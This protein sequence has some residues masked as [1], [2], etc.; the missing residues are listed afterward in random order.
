MTKTLTQVGEFG[1]IERMKR[2]VRVTP[3]VCKGIGDDAA[4]LTVTP[5]M[6]LVLTTD[7]LVE[8]VHFT[9]DMKAESVGQKAMACNVSDI[10]AMGAVPRYAVV[11]LGVPGA[12]PLRYVD[13][14]YRGMNR[15]AEK[16]A[17]AIVGGD[18]VSSEKIVLNIA[19]T[20]EAKDK[21]L[22][23]RHGAKAGDGIFVTGPLGRSFSTGRHLTF[24]P[25]LKESQFLVRHY[26]PHA[27]I[28][29]SDGLTA[30]LGHILTESRVGALLDET[31]IPRARGAS[32]AEALSDGE[33]FELLFTVSAARTKRLLACGHPGMRFYKIGEIV[34]AREG[35]TLQDCH[36]QRRP[37]P[38]RGYVHF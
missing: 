25:R 26:P 17:V 31:A 32:L 16:F 21:D 6:R 19:L 33:D 5:G 23:Y 37:L 15:L 9:R 8:D 22:V 14:L 1:L 38:R 2:H 4:V 28:D 24:T 13:G 11:S 34:C 36:G 12:L 20:G 27:M 3:G 10:A 29:I 18:T 30:D 7:M 35:L